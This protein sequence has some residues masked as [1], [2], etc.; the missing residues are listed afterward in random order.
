MRRLLLIL[1][2]L[3]VTAGCTPTIDAGDDEA[4]EESIEEV[5]DSLSDDEREE[6]EEAL[7]TLLF[8]GAGDM[9]LDPDADDDEIDRRMRE[10]IDGMTA[11][12]V[13]AEAEE[14]Q[15][16]VEEERAR[17]EAKRKE[18]ERQQALQE[19]EE[20][21][22]AREQARQ[23]RAQLDE[24]VV[25]R[26]RFYKES[27]RYGGDRPRIDLAVTN[28]TDYAISRAYFEGTLS[29][30]GRSVPWLE[31]TFNYSISGG[32]EPGES[33]EWNLSPNQFSE[34]GRVDERDDMVFTVVTTRLDG[35]DGE[36][37]F[38]D[39]FSESDERRLQKLKE[40][41]EQ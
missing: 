22:E 28:G 5:A 23:A 21:K 1:C 26:S 12:E 30:P 33:A 25:D 19:I 14:V 31:E 8:S 32:L 24:F 6:F 39:N 10:S 36:P 15:R 9:L 38:E 11:R 18:R 17:R 27:R 7:F 41:F 4:L 34:W 37:L 13:I 40:Q 2:V 29:T 3:F 35:P 16:E 20:L